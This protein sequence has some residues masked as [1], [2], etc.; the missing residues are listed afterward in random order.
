MK[1]ILV[2]CDFSTPSKE[3]YKFA[4]EIASISKGE[5]YVVHFI[6]A[7]LVYETTFGVQPHSLDSESRTRLKEEATSAF[8]KLKE[9]FYTPAKT[10]V[11]FEMPTDLM[12]SGIPKFIEEHQIDLVVMGTSGSS[13]LEEFL[14]GSNTE[15]IVRFS[16]VPVFA[17]TKAAAYGSIQHIV[18]PNSLELNQ[19]G[20]I[21]HVKNLQA[22]FK[23]KLHV[24]TVSTPAHFKTNQEAQGALEEFANHYKLNNYTLNFRNDFNER[25]GILN[26]TKEIQAQMIALGTHS[27]KGLK[28]LING[29]IAE[30]VVNHNECPVWTFSIKQLSE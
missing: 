4:L 1:K 26:F 27:Y 19:S 11:H 8:E 5:I 2:P 3:A 10:P 18:F 16:P 14:I 20:L 28:H 24:L 13:G 29:S 15:K 21:A 22:F 9:T 25:D 17:V 6:E 23:A 30:S 12:L 7:P